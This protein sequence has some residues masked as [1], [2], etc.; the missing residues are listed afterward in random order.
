MI[1]YISINGFYGVIL[2][3]RVVMQD[4][5][6]PFEKYSGYSELLLKEGTKGSF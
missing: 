2:V 4:V 6:G 5:I 3:P 1:G